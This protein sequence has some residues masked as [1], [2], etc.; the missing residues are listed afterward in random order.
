M[1]VVKKKIKEDFMVRDVRIIVYFL[2][3]WKS[4]NMYID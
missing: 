4:Y 1:G 2:Y 3:F